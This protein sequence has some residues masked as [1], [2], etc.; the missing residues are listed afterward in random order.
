[1]LVLGPPIDPPISGIPAASLVE[2]ESKKSINDVSDLTVIFSN[3]AEKAL[4][5]V[6]AGAR[7]LLEGTTDAKAADALA[8]KLAGGYWTHDYALT[9]GEAAELG[10]P[11]EIGLDP[12]VLELM[13]LYPQPVRHA[14]SVEFLPPEAPKLPRRGVERP[15]EARS[16]GE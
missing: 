8:E 6:K 3:I 12:E 11:V 9:A 2:V 16:G 15:G 13:K 14:P 10:L 7:E 5:Q 4:R 1:M